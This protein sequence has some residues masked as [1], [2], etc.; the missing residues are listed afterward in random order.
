MKSKFLLLYLLMMMM[1]FSLVFINACCTIS[2][3]ESNS[4]LYNHYFSKAVQRFQK[5]LLLYWLIFLK[6]IKC[7]DPLGFVIQ[8]LRHSF[9]SF[10]VSY[11][12]A[13]SFISNRYERVNFLE[14]VRTSYWKF[15][16]ALRISLEFK[17]DKMV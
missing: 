8:D 7:K 5:F 9:K 6:T 4:K 3:K 13:H 16:K 17:M 12:D 2:I 11:P 15:F 10:R 14:Q 1:V